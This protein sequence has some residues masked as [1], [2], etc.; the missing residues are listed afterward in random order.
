MKVYV[1]FTI[2]EI[3]KN[4]YNWDARIVSSRLKEKEQIQKNHMDLRTI[5]KPFKP[6]WFNLYLR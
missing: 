3:V 1:W 4:I 6:M 2:V 5:S